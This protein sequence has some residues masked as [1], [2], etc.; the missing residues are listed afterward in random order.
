MGSRRPSA[1]LAVS[2]VALV[3]ALAGTGYAAFRLPPG[4][5]GTSQLKPSAVTGPK[6]AKGAVTA[7]KVK[8]GSL[9][10]AQIAS[11]TLGP[12]PQATHAGTADSATNAAGTANAD[13]LGGSPPS[14]Y[15]SRV[16]GTCSSGSAIAQIGADG[17]VGCNPTG[18]GTITGVT[19]GTGLTGG[20]TSGA[21]T[22]AVDPNYVQRRVNGFCP[23]GIS[24]VDAAGA[25]GCVDRSVAPVLLSGPAGGALNTAGFEDEIQGLVITVDCAS[26]SSG[27]RQVFIGTDT[28]SATLN[29][30]YSDGTNVT[31][32]GASLPT[33]QSSAFVFT[34]KRIEGQFIYVNNN[35]VATI[36]LHALDLS[37]VGAGLGCEVQGTVQIAHF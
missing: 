31:A 11:S 34:H 20:A 7:G 8:N 13:K 27:T 15:Q 19:G 16:G 30:V 14:S 35:R 12:V 3:V 21:A 33:S 28:G 5:V 18:S 4:S 17:A 6:L 26:I 24:F 36:S 2:I 10:G 37:T 25:P 29:W 32:S 9:T 22:L 1:A 23:N